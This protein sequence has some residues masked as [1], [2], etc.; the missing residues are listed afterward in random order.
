MDDI[1]KNIKN[2]K[3]IQDIDPKNNL[4]KHLS[5]LPGFNYD[6]KPVKKF[7]EEVNIDSRSNVKNNVIDETIFLKFFA[8]VEQ[9]P[10]KS[11]SRDTRKKGE[12][13]AEKKAAK[14]ETKK[15]TKKA[16]KKAKK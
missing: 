7:L 6:N 1:L 16:A 9:K 5:N 8:N 13:K 12:K 2:I 11:N 15:A 4:L 14:K 10:P 3:E